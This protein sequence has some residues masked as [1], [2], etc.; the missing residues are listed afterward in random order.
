MENDFKT[1]SSSSTFAFPSSSE[2]M[3]SIQLLD[4][5]TSLLE[6][7]EELRMRR[8]AETQYEE[9]IGKIIMETQELKWQKETLQNQKE[10]LAKQ[11]KEAMAAFKK[12]LQ[13]KMCALEEE[14]GK[15]Q[16]ATEIKEKEI[17]G[18]KETLKA[19][20]VSKYSLQKK[21]SEME[22]KVQLHLLA[23]ED[24]QKQL[25]EI[26]KYYGT[27][28]GQFG[29]V[30]E[31][32]EKLEQNVQE[33][34]QLNKRLSALNKKQ[35]SEI[36]SLKKELEK[37]TSDL[38]KSKVTCQH[39][40]GEENIHLTIKEQ[41]FQ[42]LQ[43]RFNMELELNKKIN[44]E[45][46]HIQEAKKDIIISFQC[47]QQ[48]LQHQTQ[49]S[50]ELEAKLKMLKEKNQTLERDNELQRE[51]VKENEE[52]F[53]NLQNE[54][55]KA[56]GTWKKHVEELNGE[57]NEIKNE[58]SSL[59][60]THTKLQERYN[61]LCD[62]KKFEEDKK[63]QNIPEVNSKNSEMSMEKSE[64][65][66]QKYNSG[67][68]IKKDTLSFCSD[69]NYREKEKKEGPF[70]EVILE[71]LQL[72]EESS[73]NETDPTVSQDRNPSEISL[74]KNL[75]T[76]KELISQA[77]TL[78]VTDFRKAVTAEIKDKVGS[79]KD[80]G[81]TEFKSPKNSFLV[82]DRSIET[83]KIL[84]EGTKGFDLHNADA[85]L[86]VDNNRSSN[87]ILSEVAQHTNQKKD[88]SEDEPFERFRLLPGI[89]ENATEKEITSSDQTKADLDPSL[90]VEKNALQCQKYSLQESSNV[91]LDDKQ[92]KIN[93]MQLLNK[94]SEC[95][96]LPFKQTSV[97][98]QICNDTS[99]R[100]EPTI[101]SDTATNK[102]IS[103][104]AF[105]ENLKVLLKNSDK[106]VNIMPM[107]V[108]P[109]SSPG[110]RTMRE[111]LNEMHTSQLKSCLGYLENSATTSHLQAKNENIHTS[112]A[113]DMK[114]AVPMQTSTEIQFSNKESQID[115]TQITNATKNDLFLFVNVNERQHSLLN[116]TEKT[117]S[118]NDIVSGKIYSEGQL[119]ESCSFH[120]K[121]SGDLVNRSG[122]SAFDLSTS[123]KKTEKI[124][125]YV[126]FLDP[127][128]WSKVNQTESQT[129]STSTS[130][131]PL[132]KERP[133][134]PSANKNLV[135]VTLCKN[136][137]DIRKDI[138]PDT[139][140]INRVADTLNNSSI[141]PDPKGEPSE[142][143]NATAK[144]FYDSSFP[145]EHVE[146]KPLKSV[147]QATKIKDLTDAA[148]LSAGE[149]DWQ[150]L[151]TNQI[152]EIENF[153]SLENDNQPKK[154]KAEEMLEKMTD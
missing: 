67:Q 70:I 69:T 128:P 90:N 147:L 77:Q 113:E 34:I 58:L 118:L 76:E 132:L 45:I 17:E 83:E 84:L 63:L 143:R 44:E 2:T 60:E 18:L 43:E 151:V 112:Q 41:K 71:D 50:T 12:Q 57:I 126:N 78:N 21:V 153:L 73:K 117:E 52:K 94:E 9:Q 148:A 103:S 65:I 81:C 35:E 99:E 29:L 127:S 72:F 56:L 8:E 74:S 123:D 46:T 146:I 96:V 86:E 122:R 134:G 15:Y 30:K 98:Q 22:Q 88:V 28:T 47:M 116:N 150:S 95:S 89:Q 92:C 137:D 136:D 139:T 87:N 54:H 1:D 145:T 11:H 75:G 125:V 121:P 23:K 97:F 109:N 114:I 102:P 142:E 141:H 62:Q 36:D 61:E 149:D 42:E 108:K 53:L 3:F 4:F 38:I 80:N 6:A 59:K 16:L 20:Q 82:A 115:N 119:E 106:N 26:E 140:S 104:A 49:V 7:L 107:L 55:E 152:N 100:P 133:V 120:K 40:M 32:H 51:K 13:M 129:L 101:P 27:I 144:T 79:G 48:L 24:H 31:N 131:I 5:K 135:S 10:T 68:E 111:N 19:L 37:V 14:K 85:H 138:G 154:R 39:K 105:S 110:E 130:S 91:M 93:Q 66:I 64:N 33:A 124:P 25:N